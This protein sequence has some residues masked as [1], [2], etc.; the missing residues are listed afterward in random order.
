MRLTEHIYLVGGG[1]LGFGISHPIDSHVYLVTDGKSGALVDSGVGID[2]EPILRNI[3]DDGVSLDSIE[4]LLVT[5]AHADHSG[6]CARLRERLGLEVCVPAAARRWLEEADEDALY[7]THAK[8]GG[9]YPADYDFQAVEVGSQLTDGDEIEVGSLSLR[10][11]ET[12]G[13]SQP[14]ISY[15]LESNGRSFCSEAISCSM[16]GKSSC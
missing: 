16:A 1:D 11:I 4:R 7:L 6:G 5:H 2:I 10:A 13:H 15:L 12:P 8:K 3:R 14:H 9:R